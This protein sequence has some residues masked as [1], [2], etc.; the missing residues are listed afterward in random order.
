MSGD[1]GVSKKHFWSMA[2]Y[3]WQYVVALLILLGG[4]AFSGALFWML[5]HLEG[6]A[7]RHDFERAAQNKI[8]AF[9]KVMELDF[10]QLN[11]L[12]S[13]IESTQKINRRE[14]ETYAGTLLEDRPSIQSL[15]WVPRVPRTERDSFEKTAIRDVPQFKFSEY[16]KNN[17]LMPA[18][19]RE[20]YF[21]IYAVVPLNKN[22]APIGFDLGSDADC[23]AA[24]KRACDTGMLTATPKFR[25][26]PGDAAR[27]GCRLFLAVYDKD[28]PKSTIEER[29][30][31]LMGYAVCMLQFGNLV[32]ESIAG[33]EPAGVDVYLL[34][35]TDPAHEQVLYA[36]QSR[37]RMPNV[38]F[39]DGR[40][41]PQGFIFRLD[42]TVEAAGRRWAVACAAS[43]EF[44][45]ARATWYPVGGSVAFMLLTILLAVYLE[46]VTR[47]NFKTWRLASQLTDANQKLN[48]EI[49][50]CKQIEKILQSSETKYKT[51]FDSSVDAVVLTGLKMKIIAAN[52][53][54]VTLF[55]CREESDL[56]SAVPLDYSP[57]FQPDGIA[58]AVKARRMWRQTRKHGSHSFEWRYCRKI[59]NEFDAAVTMADMEIDG[60]HYLLST[61]RDI[62]EQKQIEQR[63]TNSLR[64]LTSVS[65]LQA[66]LLLPNSLEDKFKKIA[67]TAIDLL[68]LD[69]CRIWLIRPGDLCEEGCAHAKSKDSPCD[70][71]CPGMKQ[72][73][74]LITSSG[75]YSRTDGGRRRVPL[76]SCK[77]G[78]IAASESDKYVSNDVTNDPQV[79]D[80]E[81]AKRLGLTSFA[82]Y[83]LRDINGNAVGVLAAFSKHAMLEEDEALLGNVAELS[84]R[85]ILEHQA[86]ESLQ[87]ENAKLSAMISGMEEGVVFADAED[88]IIEVNDYF[89]HF[90][91]SERND[92]L[93]KRIEEL[94]RGPILE[95]VLSLIDRFRNRIGSAPYI[96]Q[97]PLGK[98][99]VILRMQPIYRNAKYDGVLLNVVDVS[100]LVES[101]RQAEVA[102][103]AKSRFLA[104]M[105]HE[106]RTP[107]TA[108]LG[109]ADLLMDEN[110]DN[111]N[112]V[113]YAS[114]I[115]R[116]G[117]HL[118][119]L[120]NDILD[121]S[122]IEAGKMSLNIG[123]C[124]LVSM[125]ADVASVMRPR[126][127]QRGI[128]FGIKY[129]GPI[130]ETILTDGIRL[131]QAIL[132]L[133]GNAVKFT[134]RG[135]VRIITSFI[136]DFCG[137]QP[138]VK[139]DVADTGIGIPED[140]LPRLF[141]SFEQG[142][143][144][145]TQKFGGTGL[146][147]AISRNIVHLL[148]GQM[149]V[150]SVR[151]Q[152][153]TFTLTV[154]IGNVQDIRMLRV[155]SE[156]VR[157]NTVQT[158]ETQNKD[159]LG[160]RILLAEDGY[161]NREL[162]KT[163]LHW[164]GAEVTMVENGRLA[165]EKT[166][167]ADF[168]L[169]LMDMNMPEMDGYEATRLLRS[170]GYD[171][172]IM[173]LTANAMAGDISECMAAGCNAY[174]AKPIDRT[175]LIR[176]IAAHLGKPSEPA[177]T[178]ETPGKTVG[179]IVSQYAEDPDIAEILQGFV[180]RLAGQL[181][182]MRQALASKNYDELRRAAHKLKGAGGSYGYPSLTEACRGLEN[183]A[184]KSDEAASQA[185]IDSVAAIIRAI[186]YGYSTS[187]ASE[188]TTP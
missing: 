64:R 4:A 11:T 35:I 157:E 116:S 34:D 176:T 110:A 30:R 127:E 177:V 155:P 95:H 162:L 49:A 72:C 98:A 38:D 154:P 151:G 23:R 103:Q 145:I 19:P 33:F 77:I 97:R 7:I 52:R 132:N 126:A 107:M 89:C 150:A 61:V 165:V 139:I 138:A 99:E 111:A 45:E 55:G 128:A 147:L 71:L 85:V 168:D 83:K 141:Q 109:Y 181:K 44:V 5:L 48:T 152:G 179:A 178:P 3:R 75:R 25:L 10:L 53:A 167:T 188:K 24:M 81:W 15:Q 51:L 140:V 113:Y 175:L 14:F 22:L 153:S 27:L 73:L 88:R 156:A 68:D 104:N 125:L 184:Q 114:V 119:A 106:I 29:R 120:I 182:E 37:L 26:I 18:L 115:R 13:F 129:V 57:E 121:L 149:T 80:H 180:E 36:H 82:G 131:R 59:G 91:G 84:S 42:E 87:R 134:E 2:R 74:H 40:I 90:I 135:S 163:I 164:A 21:P 122:K 6:N 146:G 187:T 170:R 8:S 105:S 16:D 58:S 54:A 20:D 65:Q 142:D 133:A 124:S 96:L 28:A 39:R 94:H 76:G 60:E 148:G 123:R 172:P 92:L 17:R 158:R 41:P 9:R 31:A 143:A 118:L 130:P 136:N 137:D 46:E 66:Y 93:G 171:K 67:E 62:T 112:R 86:A 79:R 160:V 100:E 159:L 117:E 47:R 12:R 63:R 69:F 186:E 56:L 70:K 102:N 174:M 108:I 173:A 183:A 166:A 169:I 185:A 50:E 101:R 1:L 32:E 144:S 43:P 161:D 78:R